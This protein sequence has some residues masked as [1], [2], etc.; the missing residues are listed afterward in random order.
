ML[1]TLLT[2]GLLLSTAAISVIAS[3]DERYEQREGERYEKGERYNS[4][5]REYREDEAREYRSNGRYESD[6]NGYREERYRKNDTLTDRGAQYR[7]NMAAANSTSAEKALYMKECTSCHF[8][9]QPQLLPKR[10]WVKMMGEL[11]NHFGSDASLEETD[12]LSI[13][14]YLVQNAGDMPTVS[15][16]HF[17]KINRSIAPDEAPQRISDTRYFIKEHRGIAQ[18]LIEQKEVK[19]ISNCKA[20]HTTADKGSYSERDIFIPNYGRWED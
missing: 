16:K 15:Y 20:C 7:Q 18:R 14:K 11:E 5:T 1:K 9:Y 3:D 2:A 12:R 17:K 19:S 10:S 13:E 4:Q 8:G 6:E